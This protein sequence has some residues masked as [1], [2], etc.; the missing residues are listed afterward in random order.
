MSYASE[1]DFRN[2]IGWIDKKGRAGTLGELFPELGGLDR[3]DALDAW[4]LLK[5]PVRGKGVRADDEDIII[6]EILISQRLAARRRQ[7]KN[8][9]R[10]M[11][12]QELFRQVSERGRGDRHIK[13]FKHKKYKRSRGRRATTSRS[14]HRKSTSRRATK[15]RSRRRRRTYKR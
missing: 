12:L 15:S 14:R 13:Y 3:A 8:I 7:L 4:E 11:E 2:Q 6:A 9:T 1:I 10:K 5:A